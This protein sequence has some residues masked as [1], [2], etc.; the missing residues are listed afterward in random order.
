MKKGSPEEMFKLAETYENRTLQP[1]SEN[2]CNQDA[3]KALK[4]Y[5]LAAAAG[6]EKARERLAVLKS[7]VSR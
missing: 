6:L 1:L 7:N 4:L 2:G 3:E 5:E